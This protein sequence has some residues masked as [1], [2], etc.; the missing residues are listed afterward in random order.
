MD[1]KKKF[2]FSPMPSATHI[3]KL[4]SFEKLS[5]ISQYHSA[6]TV[7]NS[8]LKAIKCFFFRFTG[9]YFIAGKYTTKIFISQAIMKIFIICEKNYYDIKLI[10]ILRT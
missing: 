8:L 9:F 6:R 4:F 10:K 2:F 5:R 7:P 3:R 1:T